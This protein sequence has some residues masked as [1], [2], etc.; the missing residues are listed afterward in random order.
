VF[1]PD[2]PYAM[3]IDTKINALYIGHLK[4]GFI[5]FIDL[6]GYATGALP[7]LLGIYSSIFPTDSN[8]STGV[9]SINVQNP[10]LPG[11][12]GEDHRVYATS[13]FLPRA[14]SFEPIKRDPT[15]TG[16]IANTDLILANS[17]DAFVTGV[18][19]AETRGIQFVDNADGNGHSRAF[20]LQ[21]TP[22]ALVAFERADG[23]NTPSAVIEVCSSPTFLDKYSPPSQSSNDKPAVALYVTCFESGEVYVVDPYAAR[24]VAIIEAGRG[25]SGLAFS[26]VQQAAYVVGFGANNI[27]VIDL[28]PGTTQYHVV[29]RIGFPTAVPF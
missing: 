23:L 9:T 22:P 28:A 20:V 17:G 10:G 11:D 5:S 21:R 16:T 18:T 6:S 3:G 26:T 25:P 13:R 2:E 12:D 29:Q 8:G 4:G 24:V 14:G 7:E 27:S 19:G 1:L 15:Q